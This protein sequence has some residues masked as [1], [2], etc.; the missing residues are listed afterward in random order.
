V[1]IAGSPEE[2]VHRFQE[3]IAP[4]VDEFVLTI[5][6]PHPEQTIQTLPNE[7]LLRLS[8]SRRLA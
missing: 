2:A 1:A 6:S 7:V 4:G 8:P 5:T 3:L